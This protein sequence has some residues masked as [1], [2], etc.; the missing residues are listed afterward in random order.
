MRLVFSFFNDTATTEIYTLP[1]HDALPIS[2][3]VFDE[4]RPRFCSGTTG[5]FAVEEQV[6]AEDFRG[7]S[8]FLVK[9]TRS[10][11]FPRIFGLIYP[12]FEWFEPRMSPLFKAGNL[13]LQSLLVAHELRVF[14]NVSFE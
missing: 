14:R 7:E 3:R 12:L 9:S 6:R 10:N 2:R 11:R 8:F 13:L 4:E 1:L 5:F